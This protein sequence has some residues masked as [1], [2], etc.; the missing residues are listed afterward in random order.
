MW[1][2]WSLGV[3]RRGPG[4]MV[5]RIDVSRKTVGESEAVRMAECERGVCTCWGRCRGEQ[6]P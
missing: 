5:V 1:Q 6:P 2:P 4:I 3:L